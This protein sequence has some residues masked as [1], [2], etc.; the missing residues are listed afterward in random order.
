MRS[1]DSEVSEQ[2]AMN[3]FE[4]EI[5]ETA[6]W[7]AS[8]RFEGIT[9]LHSARQVV[10]Q[11]GTWPWKENPQMVIRFGYGRQARGTPRRPVDDVLTRG[12][13][14]A[15]Q[16]SPAAGHYECSRSGAWLRRHDR[17]GGRRD[18][19]RQHARASDHGRR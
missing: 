16:V 3:S 12:G 2:P 6:R 8:P 17:R 14:G 1:F 15:A 13:R 18:R 19:S 5:G 7:F 10:E 9:R 11:R 4:S